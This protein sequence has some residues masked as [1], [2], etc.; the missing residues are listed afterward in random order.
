MREL[1]EAIRAERIN[2]DLAELARLRKYLL[3]SRVAPLAGR[4]LIDAIDDYVEKLTGDRRSLHAQNH[5][6]GGG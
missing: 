1:D 3:S 4:Q 5:S 2:A 6:I